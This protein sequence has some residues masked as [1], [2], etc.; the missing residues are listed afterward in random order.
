MTIQTLASKVAKVEGKKSQA[1]IG[2]V[3]E[4]LAILADLIYAEESQPYTGS[5]SA[6]IAEALYAEGEKRA[7]K[8]AK[9]SKKKSSK[10]K[11]GK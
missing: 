5:E 2:D 7:K 10:K 6:T 3:R 1:S 11:T 9:T 8:A 4:I